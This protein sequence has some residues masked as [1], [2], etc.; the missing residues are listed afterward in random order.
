MD[1][2]KLAA[3]VA[4]L[5]IIAYLRFRPRPV[6]EEQRI[7]NEIEQARQ[8]IERGSVRDLFRLVAEN[9]NDNEGHDR[10]ALRQIAAIYLMQHRV[11]ARLA[12]RRVEVTGGGATAA[13]YAVLTDRQNSGRVEL[14][15]QLTLAQRDGHWQVTRATGM[16]TGGE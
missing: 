5:A 10:Q 4:F 15:L 1:A 8:A 14:D 2:R 9:Y 12:V 7:R 11:A 13:V 6:T 3:L 16:R